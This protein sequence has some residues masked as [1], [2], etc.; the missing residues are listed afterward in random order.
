MRAFRVAAIAAC[1]AALSAGLCAPAQAASS[2]ASIGTLQVTLKDLNT[3]DNVKPALLITNG[4]SFVDLSLTGY[5]PV[6]LS[7]SG[8]YAPLTGTLGSGS[9]VDGGSSAKSGLFAY[10]QTSVPHTQYSA[11][12]ISRAGSTD[13]GM[14]GF[15]LAPFTEASITVPYHLFVSIDGNNENAF[16]S[17]TLF[18]GGVEQPGSIMLGIAGDAGSASHDGFLTLTLTNR[19]AHWMS[20]EVELDANAW[21]NVQSVP[22]PATVALWAAGLFGVGVTTRRKLRR[23]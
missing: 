4:M 17:V 21:G 7:A 22:E 5:A 3:N 14:G 19:S 8:W 20:D 13:T 23:G 6:D 16:S 1:V 18:S 10:G 12:S 2:S 15:F 9:P 11:G